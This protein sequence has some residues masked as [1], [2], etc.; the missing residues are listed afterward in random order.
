MES[1][2]RG[3][4]ISPAEFFLDQ[5]TRTPIWNLRDRDTFG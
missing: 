5:P 1:R 4:I 3:R 2:T